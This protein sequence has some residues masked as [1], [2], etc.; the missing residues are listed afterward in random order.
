MNIV[1]LHVSHFTECIFASILAGFVYLHI[2]AVASESVNPRRLETSCTNV[3]R[4]ADWQRLGEE[5]CWCQCAEGDG[6]GDKGCRKPRSGFFSIALWFKSGP[7]LH[8]AS[9]PPPPPSCSPAWESALTHFYLC[10]LS[11]DQSTQHFHHQLLPSFKTFFNFLQDLLLSVTGGQL[12]IE[13]CGLMLRWVLLLS[14]S[15]QTGAHC[16]WVTDPGWENS[17]ANNNI[18]R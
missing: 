15:L 16:S 14:L 6:N 3:H 12:M 11:W 1:H 13:T 8:G 17:K 9:S 2:S 10:L 7:A 18:D 4:A 5:K